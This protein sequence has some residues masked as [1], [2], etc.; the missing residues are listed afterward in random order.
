MNITQFKKKWKATLKS[1]IRDY[2]KLDEH[3]LDFDISYKDCAY[4][5]YK[6]MLKDLEAIKC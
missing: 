1:E 2:D 3:D 5:I 4:G 6:G